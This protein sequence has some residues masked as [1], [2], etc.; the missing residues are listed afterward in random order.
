MATKGVTLCISYKYFI[1]GIRPARFVAAVDRAL[2]P[3]T[4]SSASASA[5]LT[6]AESRS[7]AHLRSRRSSPEA[8]AERTARSQTS[9]HALRR[10]RS[11]AARL[12]SACSRQTSATPSRS[13]TGRS[14]AGLTQVR[15]FGLL[16]LPERERLTLRCCSSPEGAATAPNSAATRRSSQAKHL[17]PGLLRDSLAGSP[18]VGYA[19]QLAPF[20]HRS[21][22][23]GSCFMLLPA[24]CPPR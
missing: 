8:M 9:T 2:I 11:L 12:S 10:S 14:Q 15:S 5:R 17:G 19:T 7:F 21:V 16:P 6:S 4:R 18:R 3:A 13:A 24:H 23:A 20:E 1:L 22:A